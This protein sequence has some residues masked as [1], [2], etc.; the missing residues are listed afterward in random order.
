M[1]WLLSAD[2]HLSDRARDSYRFGLFSWLKKQQQKNK[3]DATFL[4]GDLT[5]E[6]DRHSSA[7]VNR[8]VEELLTL[9]PPV[10]VLRG[11]HDGTNP[12][13]PFFKFLNSITGLNFVVKP[14]FL[15][16]YE[17]AM[18]PHC[19]DQATLDAACKQ[20]PINPTAVFAHQTFSGAIAETGA[21][22]SGLSAAPVSAL[23]PWLGVYSGDVH[24]P[25]R[26]ADVT[27]VGAP[28]HVRFNDQ[29]EPRVLL[30]KGGGKS[31]LHFDCPRKYSLL[32]R[33]ADDI[34][35]NKALRRGDQVKITVELAREEAV[36]WHEH[37]RRVLAACRE[38]GLDVFGIDC[39]VKASRR[40]RVK[41]VE[42]AKANRPQDILEA[43]CSNEGVG[44][45]I[46][47]VGKELLT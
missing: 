16:K 4:L 1:N 34:A 36:E 15:H 43:F 2:L 26:C 32:I 45:R 31:D 25:Q 7:L 41:L 35:N 20:M 10:Y 30:I 13:S 21:V 22:L 27:Y 18:I 28:Y 12:D 42:G 47:S 5:Q 39:T 8:I 38:G 17:I 46:K 19:A 44:I 29:F 14:T 3:V 24:T 33:D 37:K 9:T 11:N 23:K 40:E 6:K